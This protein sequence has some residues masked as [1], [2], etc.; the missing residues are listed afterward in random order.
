MMNLTTGMN[1]TEV[2]EIMGGVKT[3]RLTELKTVTNPYKTE[4]TTDTDGNV[5]E[6]I[7][8]I[9]EVPNFIYDGTVKDEDLTPFAFINGELHGWGWNFYFEAKKRY[10]IDLDVDIKN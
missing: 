6:F 7:W 1:K 10:Q 5:Y 4:L 3:F 9:T 2:L 8:Y